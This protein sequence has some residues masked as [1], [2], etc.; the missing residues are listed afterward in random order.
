MMAEMLIGVQQTAAFSL[1]ATSPRT[2]KYT[3]YGH[4]G[5]RHTTAANG[6]DNR[7]FEA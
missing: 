4:L 3:R 6:V 2:C 1:S 7:R 5:E